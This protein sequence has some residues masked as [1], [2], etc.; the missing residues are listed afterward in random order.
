M[1][2]KEEKGTWRLQEQ[3]RAH[4]AIKIIMEASYE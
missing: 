4:E 3:G 2:R 1:V